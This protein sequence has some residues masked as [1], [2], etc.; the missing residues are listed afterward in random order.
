M[1]TI[2]VYHQTNRVTLICHVFG[3]PSTFYL[4]FALSKLLLTSCTPR[5]LGDF[6]FLFLYFFVGGGGGIVG[7]E[8]HFSYFLQKLE[9]TFLTDVLVTLDV[10]WYFQGVRLVPEVL[11]NE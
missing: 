1:K 8:E 11:F 2:I 3:H 6:I 5:F 10:S 9:I 7:W 4:L